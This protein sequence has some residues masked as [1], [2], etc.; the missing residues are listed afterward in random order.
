MDYNNL[1][2][3]A[4]Y[5]DPNHLTEGMDYVIVNGKVVY[6]DLKFTGQYPG[7]FVPHTGK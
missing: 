1:K 2:N 4:T 3:E 6:H 5:D 7:C